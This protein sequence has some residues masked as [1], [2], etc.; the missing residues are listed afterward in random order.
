MSADQWFYRLDGRPHG[1]FTPAQFEK[2]IRGQTVTLGTEVS[3]DGHTWK[4]LR[5]ALADVSART[6]TDPEPA[7]PIPDWMNA[8]TLIL[9]D[10]ALPPSSKPQPKPPA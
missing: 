10:T 2:L 8:P 1:P 9:G 4:S 6:T 3:I 7:S 5:E